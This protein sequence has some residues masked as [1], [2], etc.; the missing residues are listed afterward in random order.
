MV[1]PDPPF[2][3]RWLDELVEL[4]STPRRRPPRLEDVYLER[5]LEVR[6]TAADGVWQMQEC[7]SEGTAVR[8]SFPARG[9]LTGRTGVTPAIVSELLTRHGCDARP[10]SRTAPASELDAPRGWSEWA[11]ALAAR[12]GARRV[13]V[14]YAERRAAVVRA[15]GWRE[16]ATPALVRV[17]ASDE[18]AAALLA[19]WGHPRL[20][21]WLSRLLEAPPPKPW[22]PDPG[23]RLPVLFTDGSGGVLLHEL[24]GH[25]AEADLVVCGASPLVG[26]VGAALGPATLTVVDDPT[27]SDLPGGFSCDDEAVPA[28]ILPIVTDGRLAGW[29]C[30]RASGELLGH[31]PGRGRRSSWR[32]PPA[33]RLSNLVVAP[34]EEDPVAMERAV[35]RGLVV[36]R[37]GG[38]TTDT[39][40]GRV[41]LRVER[42]WELRHG[43]RRRAVSGCELTGGI[44]ATLARLDATLG[45]DAEADW[46]LGWCVKDGE[47]LATGSLCPT[48]LVHEM[49]VA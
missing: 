1:S 4:V 43:R 33:P 18:P 41:V 23:E 2:D 16:A 3:P 29:I 27:R 39:A 28:A 9:V 7:R 20:G 38:A 19:T 22:T 11:R 6:L 14:I 13:S 25:M 24:L 31:P 26:L 37:L 5:H 35:D 45:N 44:L 34:G 15:D 40:S 30:D 17:E 10:S 36:T 8:W 21:E 49:E 47:P 48:L 12:F 32:R 42:G 46:R